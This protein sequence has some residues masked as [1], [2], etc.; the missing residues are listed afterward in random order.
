[1]VSLDPLGL[2]L[3]GLYYPSLPGVRDCLLPLYSYSVAFLLGVEFMLVP[4]YVRFSH[5]FPGELVHHVCELSKASFCTHHFPCENLLAFISK[6]HRMMVL[7]LIQ[8]DAIDFGGYYLSALII[9]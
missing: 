4:L 8:S 6:I 3:L 7:V 1:M 2:V 5:N 9:T